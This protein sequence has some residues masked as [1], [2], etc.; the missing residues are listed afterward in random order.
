MKKGFE[1]IF[2]CYGFYAGIGLISAL[3]Y[4]LILSVPNSANTTCGISVNAA[5]SAQ[6]SPSR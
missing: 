5:T 1:K 6:Y 4:S 2:L 3:T